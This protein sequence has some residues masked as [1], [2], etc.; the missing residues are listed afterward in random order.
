MFTVGMV[1][2]FAG[3]G[4][5]YG[6]SAQAVTELA[7]HEINADGGVLGHE[8]RVEMIDGGAPLRVMK[9]Q[10]AELLLRQEI[11]ALAGWHISS[12]RNALIPLVAKRVPYVYSAVYEGGEQRSGT[13]CTGEVP[14]NQLEP[15]MQW[16]RENTGA[17]RWYVV[18]DDYVWPRLSFKAVKERASRMKISI[19][20]HAFLSE[21]PEKRTSAIPRLMD[22]VRRSGCDAVLM[23]MVGQNAVD[24][25][26]AFA[27]WGL[28]DRM[29]RFSPLMEENMLLASGLGATQNLYSA[30]AYFRS[31][32][33]GDSIGLV[34]RYA[35]MHGSSGPALNGPAES[36][37]EG[38]FALRSILHRAGSVD[39]T[40][41][42]SIIDG[43]SYAGPRG[44][45]E[46]TGNQATQQLYLGSAAGFDFDVLASL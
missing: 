4:G 20:G 1:V 35:A 36:C 18:G 31:L 12:V 39:V 40:A 37:Y 29:L 34:S 41:T 32:T 16:L 13:Y 17:R 46:F 6:P 24:F 2:P 38:L 22:D 45:V 3:P 8:I 33:T 10:V 9:A 28:H 21:A 26:R 43:H 44:P 14:G 5:I 19:V 30:G 23:L 27:E 42:D 25:N 15:A 7:V 11:Q